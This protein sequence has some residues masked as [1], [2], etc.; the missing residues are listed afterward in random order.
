MDD[1]QGVA[2]WRKSSFSNGGGTAC[3][4]I[5]TTAS[6]VAVRDTTLNGTGPV[7][8][9]SREAWENFTAALR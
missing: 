4:E 3:V 6:E 8:K 1:R 7:V 5:G 2:D 9:V